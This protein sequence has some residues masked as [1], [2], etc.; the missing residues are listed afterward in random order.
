MQDKNIYTLTSG[1]LKRAFYEGFCIEKDGKVCMSGSQAHFMV[2]HKF[3]SY[4]SASRWGRFHL[5]LHLPKD[6]ICVLRAFAMDASDEESE[7]LVALEKF[8]AD[9]EVP[10]TLKKERF[11]CAGGLK[12]INTEDALLYELTGE[13]LF[14][15][16]EIIGNGDGYIDH[17]FLD[18][19]GDNFMQTFPEIYQEEG[20]FFHRYMSVFSSVYQDIDMEIAH[21]DQ[22]LDVDTAPMGLLLE[23]A[24]WLGLDIRGEFLEEE[25][26]RRL[27]KEAYQLNRIKGTRQCMER[28]IFLLIGQEAVIIERKRLEGYISQEEKQIYQKLYGIDDQDIVILVDRESDERIQAQLLYL[29]NQFKP[30]R[31]RIKLVFYKGLSRLDSY[32]Y[33]DKDALFGGSQVGMLDNRQTLNGTNILK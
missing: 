29:L 27:L 3:C 17:M 21:I 6:C 33:L 7:Q 9:A 30:V 20:G 5:Q 10:A 19:Q 32:S 16:I 14:I 25:L 8:F 4:I 23:Y 31:S 13:Y 18:S 15:A 24:D 2:L 11:D 12:L 22:Y 26:L 28:L 1:K